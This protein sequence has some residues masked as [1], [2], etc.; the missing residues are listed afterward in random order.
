MNILL[1]SQCHKNA[2]TETRRILDQFAER[3]GDR[4]WQTAIT[5]AGLETL[6]QM[7]RKTARKNTAV[8]CY[9]THAKNTTDL[10]WIVG[11]KS[12]FNTQGRVPTNRT[13]RNILRAQDEDNWLSMHTIQILASLAALMHD[14]GKSTIA[15]QHKLK[16]NKRPPAD[17]YRH[18]W[19]SARLF[20]AMIFGCTT[21]KE[22]L[23]RLAHWS[24][25]VQQ[26][27]N[28]LADN[29]FNEGDKPYRQY[30][31][32]PPI[33]KAI[34]WLIVSHHR[35]PFT[36]RVIGTKT[37]NEREV[38]NCV[39]REME[40]NAFYQFFMPAEHWVRNKSEHPA[41]K[42]FW[43]FKHL[44]C[45][46]VK[47][48][49][50]LTRWANKALQHQPLQLLSQQNVAINDPFILLLA[51]LC[52]VAG[53]H[54]YSSQEADRRL[55]DTDFF[56]KL[57]ANTDKKK[58]PKQALDEHLLGVC[59]ISAKFARLLPKLEQELPRLQH[60]G[61]KQNTTQAEFKWQNKAYQLSK[62]LAA[63]SEQGGFFG[64][65]M[66]STGKGKTFANSR[67]MY[68]LNEEK[69]ARFTIA[70]GLR[71]LT[72]QTGKAL[73]KKLN[74]NDEQLAILVGGQAHKLHQ[75]QSAEQPT[76]PETQTLGSE[77]LEDWFAEN[78]VI[79]GQLLDGG[80]EAEQFGTL[81]A[82]HKAK[83]LLYSPIV[84][85][86]LDHLINASETVRGGKHIVPILRLL[87]ADLVLDE[88]D[89]FSQ[90]DLPALSRLVHLAGLFG[91]RVLLS[92]ATLTP[93]FVEGLFHAYQT[94]RRIY[95]QHR[96]IVADTPICCAWFDEYQQQS[97]QCRE[98]TQF[99]VVHQQFTQARAK[100]LA[101]E[102][103]QRKAEILS[104]PALSTSGNSE[105]NYSELATHLVR[106]AIQLHQQ[107]HTQDPFSGKNVSVGLIRFANIKPL[108]PLAQALFKL[109]FNEEF[110]AYKIHLCCY[111][112]RQL[113]LLRSALEQKLDR[114]LDRHQPEQLLT[115]QEISAELSQSKQTEH[116]FIVLGSP[117]TEVGR[118]HDYDWAIVDPSSMRSIIQLAGRVWRH[119]PHKEAQ[120]ANILLLPTNWRGLAS[121]ARGNQVLFHKPGFESEKYKLSTHQT[122]HLISPEQLAAINAI[123]RILKPESLQA[124]Q[125]LADLEHRVTA[126]LLN[127]SES[128][129]AYYWNDNYVNRLCANLPMV[130]PFRRNEAAEQ[131]DIVCL[132][133]EQSDWGFSFKSLAKSLEDPNNLEETLPEFR[134][135]PLEVTSTWIKPWLTQ[136]LNQ[137][138][139]EY[140]ENFSEYELTRFCITFLSA[141]INQ[142][143]KA[144]SDWK[145]NEALGFW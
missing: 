35:L 9:W 25:Y 26:H 53:D 42:D 124:E 2:L 89:D 41:P 31:S 58:Q 21:D 136:S 78:E 19:I 104:L 138:L 116:L 43:R 126:E 79:G 46:S 99:G 90:S 27:P 65:N 107:H 93:D 49:H 10:L 137:V 113:L 75:M 3:C 84:S 32:M 73:Q 71:V 103:V 63:S 24:D 96:S 140:S 109:P 67:I 6:H 30:G 122:E 128:T 54:C 13:E 28:W 68:A 112:S 125:K 62:S 141:R 23:E 110:K 92:S 77:S 85:C 59:K 7:L 34:I 80:L 88:P 57:I 64:V 97:E 106:S 142:Y 83:Q 1:I 69:G 101:Q 14:L 61:F 119:R 16:A 82:D 132:P 100:K 143:E 12:Q 18:E 11:D 29:Q 98:A 56:Q 40:L 130:T 70:L 134:Y 81:L 51:R 55:G 45:E 108:I 95:N 39:K 114:I 133:N 8:A 87:T 33:A 127:N 111:H 20:E 91:S 5:Q 105:L 102:K 145:F 36:S 74:L 120:F 22:W 48:Q 129:V 72:L 121:Q 4:V 76:E 139:S 86:T 17:C 50:A 144:L 44:A 135:Q 115:Q 38:A 118:D 52:L 47:W 117:V 123:P 66:A 60:K 131:C 94:G 37:S 15:F